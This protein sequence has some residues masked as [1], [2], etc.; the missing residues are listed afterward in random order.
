MYNKRNTVHPATSGGTLFAKCW[1]FK[2]PVEPL[3]KICSMGNQIHFL[4]LRLHCKRLQN[5]TSKF[6]FNICT[7]MKKT[8][9]MIKKN[10]QQICTLI[11]LKVLPFI[12]REAVQLN[13]DHSTVHL[14]SIKFSFRFSAPGPL[15]KAK[16][17]SKYLTSMS[18]TTVKEIKLTFFFSTQ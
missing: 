14:Y 10:V 2:N 17:M 6:N 7:K 16:M 3:I 13:F 15:M 11:L 4:R 1:N 5:F 18:P 8:L 12:K 9:S